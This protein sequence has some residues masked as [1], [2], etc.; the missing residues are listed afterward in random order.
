MKLAGNFRYDSV[1]EMFTAPVAE[2]DAIPYADMK[3]VND[4]KRSIKGK[5]YYFNVDQVLTACANDI[6][7]KEHAGIG[8]TIDGREITLEDDAVLNQFKLWRDDEGI[9]H[10]AMA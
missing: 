2:K 6:P 7:E 10:V 5:G 1:E 9:A 8:L 3:W 4:N